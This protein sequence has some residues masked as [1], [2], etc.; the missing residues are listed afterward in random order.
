MNPLRPVSKR[1]AAILA[2]A[3]LLFGGL[4]LADDSPS[5]LDQLQA[6]LE[7]IRKLIKNATMKFKIGAVGMGRSGTRN[8][9]VTAQCCWPNV[10]RIRKGLEASRKLMGQLTS[11]Y[12]EHGFLVVADTV[13]LVN[14][15]LQS[16]GRAIEMFSKAQTPRDADGSIAGATRSYLSLTRNFA[17]LP[18]CPPGDHGSS[19]N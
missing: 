12:E 1:A 5:L 11:C 6:E 16:V 17:Q 4:A 10:E 15:D 7:M 8:Q 18:A 3:A 9:S 2:A 14:E 19:E 13:K